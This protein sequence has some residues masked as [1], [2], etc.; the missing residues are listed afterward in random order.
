MFLDFFLSQGSCRGLCTRFLT[1][2]LNPF[3]CLH[4]CYYGYSIIWK[5]GSCRTTFKTHN[6]LFLLKVA[7]CGMYKYQYLYTI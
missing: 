7:E 5:A 1:K 4:S 2:V 3:L 6:M